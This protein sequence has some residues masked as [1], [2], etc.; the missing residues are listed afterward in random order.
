[1]TKIGRAACGI[2]RTDG[3]YSRPSGA[4]SSAGFAIPRNLDA[5]LQSAFREKPGSEIQMNGASQRMMGS[6]MQPTQ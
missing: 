3:L 6:V 1:M 2:G 5:D 4:F